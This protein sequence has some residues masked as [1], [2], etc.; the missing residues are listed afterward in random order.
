MH[1]LKSLRKKVNTKPTNDIVPVW[2]LKSCLLNISLEWSF[3][4]LTF[5]SLRQKRLYNGNADMILTGH[6]THSLLLELVCDEEPQ[7]VQ[8]FTL[9]Q[10]ALLE[11][12]QIGWRGLEHQETA[13]GEKKSHLGSA[14]MQSK[15]MF[16][17]LPRSFQHMTKMV[18]A[19]TFS[20]SYSNLTI[21]STLHFNIW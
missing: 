1:F 9:T 4:Q 7:E 13:K 5:T 15:Y 14:E 19:S 3:L 17:K 21:Y 6:L 16:W 18:P 11:G 2:G 20:K 12:W 8:R 10:R